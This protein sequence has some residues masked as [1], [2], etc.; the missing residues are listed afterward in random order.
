MLHAAGS[1]Q[2]ERS[3][4]QLSMFCATHFA[5]ST[6]DAR[7]EQTSFSGSFTSGGL[8]PKNS[9]NASSC[10]STGVR[11]L[12]P[13]ASRRWRNIPQRPSAFKRSFNSVGTFGMMA[14]IVRHYFKNCK[15]FFCAYSLLFNA[16]LN[17]KWSDVVRKI[18]V[19]NFSQIFFR[20]DSKTFQ[21]HWA[22]HRHP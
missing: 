20:R 16:I 5:C 10:A 2:L 11:P 21:Q 17:Q 18:R 13:N 22:R 1:G 15:L 3:G 9:A 19:K 4:V 12:K 6:K 7:P 8:S 14:L